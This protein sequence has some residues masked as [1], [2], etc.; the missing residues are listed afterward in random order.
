MIE[1]PKPH[2]PNYAV[3]VNGEL[4]EVLGFDFNGGDLKAWLRGTGI[5]LKKHT[6]NPTDI[7]F[8][9]PEKS[10]HAYAVLPDTLLFL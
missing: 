4:V 7:H 2:E 3:K 10:P 8:I 5:F 6:R 9:S 1:K